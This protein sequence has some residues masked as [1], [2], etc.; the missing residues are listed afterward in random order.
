MSK[1]I[2]IEDIEEL[3][4]K[5]PHKGK[6]IKKAAKRFDRATSSLRSNWFANSFDI[7]KDLLEEVYQFIA[8]YLKELEIEVI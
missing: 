4:H 2:T 3:Y 7:P 1:E 6:F 5:I 8:D